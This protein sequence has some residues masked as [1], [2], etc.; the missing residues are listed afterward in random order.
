ML[1]SKMLQPHSQDLFQADSEQWQKSEAL[2]SMEKASVEGQA[3]PLL[4]STQRR[5]PSGFCTDAA[6]PCRGTPAS[7]PPEEPLRSWG[8]RLACTHSHPLY[9]DVTIYTPNPHGQAHSVFW[10]KSA[11]LVIF[12]S[13]NQSLQ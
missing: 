6:K 13:R 11:Q 4:S 5:L 8:I 12:L 3:G 10:N 9:R 1:P 7:L 2:R